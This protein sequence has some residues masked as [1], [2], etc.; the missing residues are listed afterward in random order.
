MKVTLKEKAYAE[1]KAL[2][3]GNELEPGDY[4]TERMLE[5]RLSMSRTPIRSA[6]ERL[7]SEG[8]VRYTPNKGLFVADFSIQRAVDFYDI[9]VALESHIVRKL[10]AR[11][12]QEDEL[13]WFRDNLAM[14]KTYADQNDNAGFTAADSAF[15]LQLA[16]YHDNS[17][18]IQSMEN[19]QDKLYRIAIRVLRKDATRIRVSYDDHVRIF[20]CIVAGRADEAATAMTE[21]LEYGKR[22]LIH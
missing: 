17:E 9:R 5:E 2:I 22:I 10:S 12:W 21:H 1:L 8:L 3:L 6:L 20:A 14:Q 13:A 15:H 19:L 7:E 11:A 18:I 16:K 4:L